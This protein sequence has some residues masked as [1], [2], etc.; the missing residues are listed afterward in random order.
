MKKN[1]IGL[2]HNIPQSGSYAFSESSADVMTQVAS[3]EE[4]LRS[5]GYSS[6]RIPFSRDIDAFLATFREDPVDMVFN[7]CETVDEN[8]LFSGHA[9]V[10]LEL[11]GVPFTG[12]PSS[13]ITYTM[14]KAMTKRILKGCGIPTPKYLIYEGSPH[15]NAGCL[16]FPVIVKPRCEDASIGIDQESVFGS[17][18]TLKEALGPFY[19]RFGH[20]LVEEYIDGREFNVSLFGYPTADVMPIAE[21]DFSAFPG[22]IHR[23]VGYRAKWDTSSPE[24]NNA[25]RTFPVDLPSPLHQSLEKIALECFHTFMLR[26]YV[27][28]DIRTDRRNNPYVLEIN[29][30]PCISPD[31]GFVASLA[32][33]GINYTEM[34]RYFVEFMSLRSC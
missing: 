28:V 32:Q 31:A 14:D 19:E 1:L 33:A 20:L 5:L 26:D 30:N 15:F 22:D 27:R 2:V 21:I 3:I 6:R 8:P 16:T 4:A 23:I 18:G 25:V 7:L 29:A 12:S 34:V 11:L 10:V 17:E 13:A 9:A 24:Y